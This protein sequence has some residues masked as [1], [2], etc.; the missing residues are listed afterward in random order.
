MYLRSYHLKYNAI[1]IDLNVGI[2]SLRRECETRTEGGK[3]TRPPPPPE[4]S[5]EYE[6]KSGSKANLIQI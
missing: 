1:I 6:L 2:V 5:V 3:N 4:Q